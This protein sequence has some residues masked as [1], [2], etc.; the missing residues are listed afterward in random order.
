MP[1]IVLVQG[2]GAHGAADVVDRYAAVGFPVAERAPFVHV[3]SAHG[4][5]LFHGV[6]KGWF[7]MCLGG[8]S[9]D[10]YCRPARDIYASS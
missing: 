3:V 5:S 7:Y 2:C 10:D 4:Y 6:D 8:V 1:H 9:F